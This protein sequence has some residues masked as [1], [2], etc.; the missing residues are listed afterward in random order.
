MPFPILHPAVVVLAAGRSAR[1]GRPKQLVSKDGSTLLNRALSAACD[2]G[3]GPVYAIIGSDAETICD[4]L[5]GLPARAV[6]NDGWHEGIASSIRCGVHHA[7]SDNQDTDGILFMACD[8][9]AVTSDTLRNLM[10][11]REKADAPLAA[12]SYGGTHGI[13]ALFHGSLFD[14]LIALKG[15]AG[16]KQVMLS[17]IR[18]A[19]FLDFPEGV[20]DIDTEAECI[21]WLTEKKEREKA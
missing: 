5:A 9:P 16:A 2:A 17:R 7:I 3:L 13:P 19:V 11:I 20:T 1:L 14:E 12:C 8:Q 15:D 21:A 10:E 4:E 18:E 6:F